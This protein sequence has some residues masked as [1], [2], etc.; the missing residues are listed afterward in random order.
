MKRTLIAA[1]LLAA[2]GST[3]AAE[4]VLFAGENFRG[5]R[6]QVESPVPNLARSGFNEL[7]SSISVRRGTWQACDDSAFRGNCVT[8]PEGDY[9]TV[10]EM[11]LQNHVAS[12]REVIGERP[13]G[14]VTD[15]SV[16]VVPNRVPDRVVAVAPDRAVVVTPDARYDAPLPS[17]SEPA[18][19]AFYD[20]ENFGGRGVTV[21][22]VVGDFNDISFNDRTRSVIVYSGTWELC[23]DMQFRGGCQVLP[24]GRYAQLPN[25]LDHEVSSARPVIAAVGQGPVPIGSAGG[26]RAV[27]YEGPRFTGRQYVVDGNVLRN[28]DGTGF[29]DRV[30]SMRIERGY[31]LFCSDAQFAGECMTFGPGDYAQL[32]PALNNRVSSGRRISNDY[33]YREQPHWGG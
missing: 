13:L 15:R 10:R 16:D 2:S 32:P 18:R 1:A 30:S 9:P 29:N 19:I 22:D 23:H 6:I 20:R 21:T 25:G 14:I 26:V 3:L 33:P 4:I 31:W 5:P 17:S 11:G 12:V 24:P 28:L 7:A 27:L 8:L